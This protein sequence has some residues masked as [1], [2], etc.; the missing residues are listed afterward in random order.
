M[1]DEG[2]DTPTVPPE[3]PRRRSFLFEAARLASANFFTSFVQVC[4]G[5]A[6][7]RIWGVDARGHIETVL[8]LPGLLSIVFDLGLGRAMPYTIG[9]KLAP[10]KSLISTTL[11]M[12]LTASIIGIGIC[13]AYA[14]SQRWEDIPP[15][16]VVLGI[17]YL[18]LRLFAGIIL[19]FCV[20]VERMGFFAGLMWIRD[21]LALI[22][23][24][25]LAAI[26]S[27]RQTEDAWIRIFSM[28][29]GFFFTAVLGLWLIRKY[30]R[31]TLSID[32]KLLGEM[33]HRSVTFGLGP[34]FM[35]LLQNTPSMLLTI[36]Y[37]AVPPGDIGNYTVGAAIAM[38]LMQLAYAIGHVLMSRSVNTTD[39]AEISRKTLRLLRV[40]VVGATAMGL[41]MMVTA[42]ILVPLVYGPETDKAPWIT[43]LLVPGIV[44]FF[45]LHTL[46]TDLI[47]KGRAIVVARVAGAALA[48][49]IGVCSIYSIP[50][51]G[52]WGAAATT[53]L[54]YLSAA[55]AML[56]VYTR[57]TGTPLREAITLRM[58]DFPIDQVLGRLRR[59]AKSR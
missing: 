27:L 21:P 42:P 51:F 49:N 59:G 47:A 35:D 20:G 57:I 9:R 53:A 23:L 12:W 6:T 3:T 50:A 25:G 58:D 54:S 34:L 38:L 32:R 52:L 15:L 45:A 11:I 30:T 19:G 55:T 44:G 48:V 56:I 10:M 26:P 4:V 5:I 14:M 17:A 2:T 16:W 13:A 40:G 43:V 39:A 24:L 31:I 46:S 8:A 28:D 37:F 7:I 29:F 41:G 33:T 18:P 1:T 22:M 36:S